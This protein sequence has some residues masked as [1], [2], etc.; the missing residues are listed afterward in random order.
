[1]EYTHSVPRV[2]HR[3]REWYF[4]NSWVGQW[5]FG[6]LLAG[7]VDGASADCW[8]CPT[9]WCHSLW[10]KILLPGWNYVLQ[11]N[12][13]PLGLLPIPTGNHADKLRRGGLTTSLLSV[14]LW[15]RTITFIHV[16]SHRLFKSGNILQLCSWLWP[17]SLIYFQGTCCSDGLHCCEYGYNCDPTSMT[18]KKSY[19]QIPSGVKEDAK[20]YWLQLFW[21]SFL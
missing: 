21:M 19:S 7:P 2:V 20:D 4:F 5:G 16:I 3:F 12:H 17:C 14:R 9:E 1:M 15:C 18:C 10:W 11:G 8:Q 6:Y 13:R